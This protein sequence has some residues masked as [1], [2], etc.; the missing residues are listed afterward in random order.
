[1]VT[2]DLEGYQSSPD[3][4]WEY[5]K[6]IDNFHKA[7]SNISNQVNE[8]GVTNIN[9]Q[10][11]FGERGVMITHLQILYFLKYSLLYTYLY[12]NVNVSICQFY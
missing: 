9:D 8:E 3:C 7:A 4:Y 10:L 1:M 6:F 5:E 2:D 12:G 11:I